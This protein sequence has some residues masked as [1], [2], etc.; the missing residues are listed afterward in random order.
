MG[1]WVVD[2]GFVWSEIATR[3]NSKMA[4]ELGKYLDDE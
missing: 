1:E 4:R 3:S 2:N